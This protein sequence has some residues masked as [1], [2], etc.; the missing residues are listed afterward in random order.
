MKDINMT[1]NEKLEKIKNLEKK[2]ENWKGFALKMQELINDEKRSERNYM[3]I[4]HHIRVFFGIYKEQF[5]LGCLNNEIGL[6]QVNFNY[7]NE[8]IKKIEKE[9]IDL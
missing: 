3:S 2:L 8:E 6:L 1:A 9:I 4:L 5:E 7:A